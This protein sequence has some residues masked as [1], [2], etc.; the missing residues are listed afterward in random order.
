MRVRIERGAIYHTVITVTTLFQ[1]ST[2]EV[3]DR[4]RSKR[5]VTSSSH[6]LLDCQFYGVLAQQTARRR[7]RVCRQD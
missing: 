6:R 1:V 7:H 4:D 5:D 3:I 2:D